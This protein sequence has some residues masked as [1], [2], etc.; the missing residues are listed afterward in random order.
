MINT[1]SLWFDASDPTTITQSGG[2]V[3]Q[4]RDKSSN[5]YSVSQATGSNQ[6]TYATNLLNGL[7]GIQLSASTYLYQIGSSMPNFSSAAATTV[8]IVAK[9]G[10]T[11]GSGWNILNTLW[12]T[13][14]G[15]GTQRYHFSFAYGATS[16][17]TLF[18]NSAAVASP[19]SY[20]VPSNTNA[21]IGFAASASSNYIYYNGSNTAYSSAAA[22]VSAND[23][24]WF[25]F[26]DARFSNLVTDENIYE[27]LGFNSILTT[28][29]Q[30]LVE[31]YLA[32]KWGLQ[33]SLSNGH[34]F[35]T[36]PLY[37]IPTVITP[38]PYPT[39]VVSSPEFDPRLI[40]SCVLWLDGQDL[41]TLFQNTAGTTPV[42]ASSQ[43]VQ[44][45]RD[46]SSTGNNATSSSSSMTYSQNGIYF[47]G[48]QT[49]GLSLSASQ[50]PNGTA[51]STWFFVINATTSSTVVF[52]GAGSSGAGLRQFYL[53]GGNLQADKSGVGGISGTV[54]ANTGS[55]VIFSCL[56]SQT[57]T[58]L[59]GWQNGAQFGTTSFSF[60]IGTTAATIGSDLGSY[61]YTGY[62][63][64]LLVYG[65]TLSAVQRQQ[66]EAYL[67]KKWSLSSVLSTQNQ[68]APGSK[69]SIANIRAT[70]MLMSRAAKIS[71]FVPTQISGCVLWLDGKDPAGTG[72]QPIS[73]AT[74]S[75]WVDKSTSGKNGTATGTPTY[76]SP[77]INFTGT[78]YFLNQ[79][80][81]QNLS[82]RSIF[83]IMQE[84]TRASVAGVFPLIPNPSSGADYLTTTG[85]SI[86]TSNGLR[87]YG[88]SGSYQS[89][90]GNSVLL[91]KA[92]YNDNMNG[93]AGSSYLNG[94]IVNTNTA[95]YTAG[96]CSGYG[97]GA[98]WGGSVSM[99]NRLNG[100][101]FE[102]IYFSRPLLTSERQQVEGYLA[103]KWG[104]KT[105]LS[106]DHPNRFMPSVPS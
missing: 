46:K 53:A 51:D 105:S 82:Q 32:T 57:T 5:A 66:V 47:P 3:S 61:I 31:G 77:G 78:S 99:T 7:P 23:S 75:T 22:P 73:G 62:V 8:Y 71:T 12:F 26:G 16:G 60:N 94:T 13:G 33:S 19:S 87:F 65:A 81:A 102:I 21:I 100:I 85:L 39:S 38:V 84:T 2:L 80:F 25:I 93:T 103:W 48:T 4:W 58:T 92:I 97:V 27:F 72:A 1:L 43:V 68:F 24:T 79:T 91:V 95:G 42:T 36:T 101:I 49:T 37:T 96:T 76:S 70:Q 20:V 34:P 59:T 41:T 83:I 35:K 90:F 17:I 11:L 55:N 15:G 45:W 6:P 69:L 50:L 14:A 9:N 98:R 28:S 56:Q 54:A 29:Q 88:N 30:Q 63:G 86:E 89:D 104:L 64:E 67:A 74:V 52:M 106:A 44:L 18:V 40:P 10:T